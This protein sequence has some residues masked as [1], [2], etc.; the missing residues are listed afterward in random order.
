VPG[1]DVD[2]V[3]IGA[4]AAGLTALRELDRAGHSVLCFEARGRI[5]GRIL[6]IHDPLSPTPIELGAEFIHGRPPEIWNIIRSGRL[7]AYDCADKAVHLKNGKPKSGRAPWEEVDRVMNDMKKAASERDDQTFADFLAGSRYSQDAKRLATSYVEG[8]NAARQEEISIASLAEDAH[9]ADQ[10][11]GDRSFR[12]LNGYESVILHLLNTTGSI[13]TRLRLNSVVERIE[14]EQG[15][16]NIHVRSSVTGAVETVR[17]RRVVI[18]VPLGVLQMA[19]GV[20]GSIR[21]DPEPVELLAAARTLRFGQVFRLVLRF[22]EAFWE[23]NPDISD[24]GFLFSNEQLFP[25]WWT[26]L[27]VH[28]P[29]ITGW[30]AGPHADDLLGQ[31]QAIVTSAGLASLARITG[32]TREHL[33][34]LLEASYLHDWHGDPFARGAYTYVPAGA[35]AARSKLAGP[36]AETLF[37]AGEATNTQGHGG[38]VHGAIASGMRAARQAA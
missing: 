10:I 27:P 23:S 7:T 33:N 24:A 2:V 34:G 16:A 17:T 14:W 4:G 25:T 6:T 1:S 20:P 37:F 26:T 30:S 28:A 11:D 8:F 22:R 19:P 13:A 32:S 35:L 5:G 9:A 36:V 12:I 21:F 31:T 38:T 15:S 3:V 18:T 29:V